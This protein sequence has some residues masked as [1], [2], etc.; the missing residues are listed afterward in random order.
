MDIVEK[1]KIR[2]KQHYL[3]YVNSLDEL[4]PSDLRRA[5]FDIG[6]SII[7][8]I[9]LEL[10]IGQLL[11]WLMM[12]VVM[13]TYGN[14]ILYPLL[15]YLYSVLS[16][17][18][19]KIAAFSFLYKKYKKIKH[20]FP[21]Y[22]NKFYYPFIL[23]FAIF[24][25]GMMGSNITDFLNAVF[26]LLFGADEI[27]N[28]MEATAPQGFAEAV[29]N[30][31]CS[32][33]IAPVIEEYIYRHLLLKPLRIMGDAPAVI[34]SALIF[35]LAHGNFDQFAYCFLSGIIFS[36]IAIRYDSLKMPILL[37]FANN[38]L[39]TVII[40]EKLLM[41]GNTVWDGIISGIAFVG[42][43]IVNFSYYLAPFI[44]LAVALSGIARVRP[45]TAETEAIRKEKLR[46]FL[47]PMFIFSLFV[48]LMMFK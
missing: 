20:L 29:I 48:M 43:Y 14:D 26:Q 32:A 24:A 42:S 25:F 12:P 35:G 37:H 6:A 27:V 13:L 21:K 41:C 40:Y 23:F 39:V 44:A 9:I 18:F 34:L 33:I 5:A 16:S 28:V 17:Y 11:M 47:C 46:T 19:P 7:G 2:Y 45:V 4:Q 3:D 36:L 38:F 30:L 31:S 8:A 1:I 22:E 15:V 10:I